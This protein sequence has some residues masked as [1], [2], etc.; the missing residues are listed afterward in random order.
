MRDTPTKSASK[1][2]DKM[3]ERFHKLKITNELVYNLEPG[4][5][6]ETTL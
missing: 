3:S 6:G 4:S 2:K 5:Q 1:S